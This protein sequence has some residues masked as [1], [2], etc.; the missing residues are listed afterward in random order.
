MAISVKNTGCYI[1]FL[2]KIWK[3]LLILNLHSSSVPSVC[4]N[5]HVYSV[6]HRVIAE[7]YF[8]IPF[9][10]HVKQNHGLIG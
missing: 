4:S 9:L 5:L 2:N 7:I 8:P 10:L 1:K 6:T 3:L